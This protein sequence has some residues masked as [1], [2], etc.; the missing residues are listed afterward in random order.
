MSATRVDSKLP[1]GATNGDATRLGGRALSSCAPT[2]GEPGTA[3]IGPALVNAIFAATG[4]RVRSLP[5]TKE[6]FRAA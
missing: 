4:K 2:I 6:G 1:E 5:I 3:V